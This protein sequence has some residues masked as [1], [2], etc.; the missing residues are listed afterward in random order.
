MLFR[1]STAAGSPPVLEERQTVRMMQETIVRRA[2][3]GRLY[4]IEVSTDISRTNEMYGARVAQMAAMNRTLG[5]CRGVSREDVLRKAAALI[6]A[7]IPGAL[8]KAA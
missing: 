7:A 4:T 8:P 2:G 6:D 1:N 5:V 3:S